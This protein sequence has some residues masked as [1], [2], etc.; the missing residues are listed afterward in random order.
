MNVHMHALSSDTGI[1]YT[2][3]VSWRV[4]KIVVSGTVSSSDDVSRCRHTHLDSTTAVDSRVMLWTGG[5]AVD[6]C[7]RVARPGGD[8]TG[9][10]A[11]LRLHGRTVLT[12]SGNVKVKNDA[13]SSESKPI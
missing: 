4:T 11:L 5:A 13:T 3:R 7:D 9:A 10:T 12:G 8:G 6:G 2:L 1:W